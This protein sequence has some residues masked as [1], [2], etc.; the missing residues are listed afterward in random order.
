MA[1]TT[2]NR[3]Q[4]PAQ[5]AAGR[6]SV[7][8]LPF[9]T[10]CMPAPAREFITG[11]AQAMQVSEA[12]VGPFVLGAMSTAIGD[13]RGLWITRTFD[14]PSCLWIMVSAPSGTR[15]SPVM[16]QVF[17]PLMRREHAYRLEHRAAMQRYLVELRAWKREAKEAEKADAEQP[18]EPAR[19]V[20]R[21]VTANDTTFE[22]LVELLQDSSRGGIGLVAD[23]G[24]AL[25]GGF[26]RY[27]SSNKASTEEARWFPLY[28]A[29][30]VDQTRKT[31]G[32][33]YVPR[34]WLSITAGIQPNI[35]NRV[36]SG[37]DHDSGLVP[38]FLFSQP[39]LP[40]QR[41]ADARE[42]ESITVDRYASMIEGLLDLTPS[43]DGPWFSRF[44]DDAMDNWHE[45]AD[46]C[47]DHGAS[48]S[49]RDRARAS[50]I[51]GAAARIALIVH[52]GRVTTGLEPALDIDQVD[53]VSLRAGIEVARWFS[54][55]GDRIRWSA[56][57]LSDSAIVALE[58]IRAGGGSATAREIARRK[59]RFFK[60]MG[61]LTP[62][63]DELCE[64]GAVNHVFHQREPGQ[65]GPD[66]GTYMIEKSW[67]QR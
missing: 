27:S 46:E 64:K 22:K 40:V 59:Y 4:D 50:K 24:A 39:D 34:A 33:L 45:W 17:A 21:R 3:R 7:I 12:M 37:T 15:K 6:E 5:E 57:Q 18:D 44:T 13:T 55:Q 36:F 56:C 47:N 9:P 29:S 2:P 14:A 49:D 65:R 16:K 26:T 35:L 20:E 51:S 10:Q 54:R 28:D 25:I 32:N 38:R 61:D 41:S 43:D 53:P 31:S 30:V 23:E 42:L 63:L 66:N 60:T 48:G 67:D 19:P 1:E 62:V 58:A 52:I 8:K 11:L